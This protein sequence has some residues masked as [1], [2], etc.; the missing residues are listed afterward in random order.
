MDEDA[1]MSR[2]FCFGLG[3][4]AETLARRSAR[5]GWSIAGTARDA[6]NIERLRTQ[7]YVVGRF[8]SEPDN[9]EIPRLLAGTTHLLLSIPPGPN[10]DPVLRHYRDRIA[11]LSTLDWIGYL[12]TVGVYGDHAGAL[13]D[14]TTPPRPNSE[15]TKARVVAESDWLALGEEIG[16]PVQVFRLAG[17]YGPGRSALDKIVAGTA[18]RVVKPGQMFNRI[19][20]ED[21]ATV[22]EASMARPRAGGIY[23]VADDEPAAPDEVIAY[24]ADLLGVAPPPAVPF[25]EAELTPM[26]R[27]FYGDSRRVSNARIKS[28]LGVRLAYP[29]YRAG[30]SS[31]LA[32]RRSQQD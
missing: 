19:H 27:S 12:S 7:G 20:V 23:N 28:E 11:G 22:L 1:R 26:A 10:G 17:I 29:S 16:R 15:R 6:T 30:L 9:P 4:S 14:E 3:Y 25:A 2:L 32:M 8:T 5:K 18:R 21:I 31:L 24:A 13:V